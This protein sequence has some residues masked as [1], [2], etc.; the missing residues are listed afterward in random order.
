VFLHV[1]GVITSSLMHRENLVRAMV[2]GR[3]RAP[4]N[5]PVPAEARIETSRV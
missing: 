4:S 1:A 2:N 5:D 3:K